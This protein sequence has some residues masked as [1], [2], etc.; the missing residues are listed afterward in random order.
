MTQR[1]EYLTAETKRGRL[2]LKEV[3]EHSYT[4]N[5]DSVPPRWARVRVVDDV[6]VS[7]ILVDPRRRMAFPKGDLPYAFI[8]DVATRKDR[9]RE[10]HFRAIMEDTFEKLRSA[11][12]AFVITHGR[13]Q[14][15]RRF[16]FDLFTH[17]C[18]VFATPE[19]IER[20]LG[21]QA[22]EKGRDFLVIEESRHV[23]ED[24]LLIA[25][26]EAK[27]MPECRAAL[28]AAAAVARERGKARILF[29][30]PAAPSYGSRYP[31]YPSPETPFMIL[32]VACGAEVR[33]RDADPESGPIPDADWIKVLDATAFVR[34]ALEC[35]VMPPRSLP[36]AT[37]CLHTD[38]GP[39]T[40]E[41]TGQGASVSGK[42]SSG[43]P[44]GKWPS[45]AL[46]QLV[47][48]Y[49]SAEALDTIHD[50][51]LSPEGLSLLD[52][53]FPRRW[54]FSRN[55]SWTFAS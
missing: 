35:S 2:A 44:M 15:Y 23:L 32:A 54:R 10:G 24:L 22:S 13:Y 40:I 8:C 30:H 31:V 27:T 47:V 29:E 4:A 48:G 46:A 3:M 43:V 19:G 52:L 37:V 39:V 1:I 21:G 38:A 25:D 12:I 53:L 49:Q 51:G 55:E 50:T 11:G 41:S 18:G 7:F 14:L 17:H 6:P 42:M 33:V 26:L 45:S 5:T 16:G 34:G 28:Q 36:V 20:Q 9:R